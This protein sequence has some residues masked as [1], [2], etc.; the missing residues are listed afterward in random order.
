DADGRREETGD[1][2]DAAGASGSHDHA[3]GSIARGRKPTKV[4]REGSHGRF[5]LGFDQVVEAIASDEPRRSDSQRRE[6]LRWW[7]H[8]GCWLRGEVELDQI[9]P[10]CGGEPSAARLELKRLAEL[11]QARLPEHVRGCE[12]G[13]AAEIDFHGGSEPAQIPKSISAPQKSG[14]REVHL[15]RDVLHPGILSV[16]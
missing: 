11:G 3:S 9:S 13:M 15:A 14:F 7:R 5:V 10:A 4:G 1:E 8:F 12:S 6:E 16:P 2:V